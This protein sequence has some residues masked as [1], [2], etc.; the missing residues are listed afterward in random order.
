MKA[1]LT[2]FIISILLAISIITLAEEET[3]S[4]SGKVVI[5][6]DVIFPRD[7]NRLSYETAGSQTSE[8]EG[9][10][11][12]RK[13]AVM[14]VTIFVADEKPMDGLFGGRSY[15]VSGIRKSAEMVQKDK[16]FIPH[17]LPIVIGT[18]VGFPN[19]D[20]FYHNVFSFTRGNKFDLGKYSRESPAKE[21]KFTN[22]GVRMPGVIEIFCDIHRHM[23]GY[24]LVLE[25]PFFSRPNDR[26]RFRISE[27]PAGKWQVYVW[28]P[29]FEYVI[30]TVEIE[31]NNVIEL[32]P[33]S[34]GH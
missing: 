9:M 26:G 22:A 18:T 4:I 5:D 24:V 13:M 7:N 21:Y 29:L 16:T 8:V 20:P 23:K 17:V 28:H 12:Q 15:D 1:Q 10:K 19:E 6:P 2:F 34:I 32:E 31:P 27:V 14:D 30:R 25:N 11:A 33:I 3:G